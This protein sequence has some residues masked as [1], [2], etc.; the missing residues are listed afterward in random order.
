VPGEQ[1]KCRW[2]LLARR[3]AGQEGEVVHTKLGEAPTELQ[4]LQ[5]LRQRHILRRKA[6]H[7]RRVVQ[8]TADG[9]A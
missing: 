5:R 7:A 1:D 8:P 2:Q 4:R 6:I 3:M 9:A